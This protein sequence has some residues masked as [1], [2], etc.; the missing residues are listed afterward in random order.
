MVDLKDSTEPFDEG[1]ISPQASAP[2]KFEIAGR[3]REIGALI[4]LKGEN[5]FRAKAYEN[6]ASALESIGDEL[7][8][9]IA[10]DQLTA[11]KGIG[12]SI[13]GVINE[14]YKTGNAKSLDKLKAEFPPGILELGAIPG[15]SVKKVE[16]LHAALGISSINDLKNAIASNLI[17][18][19]KGFSEKSQLNIAEALAA[20]EARGE[21]M[22]LV[23]AK[24]VSENLLAYLEAEKCVAKACVVG[25]ISRWQEAVDKIELVASGENLVKILDAF[26]KFPNLS[27]VISRTNSSS[28]A[29]LSDSRLFINLTVCTTQD[30]VCTAHHLTGTDD[31]NAGLK[32]VAET[33]NLDLRPNELLEKGAKISLGSEH[34]IYDRLGLPFIPVELREDMQVITDAVAGTTYD[35]LIEIDDIRGMTHCHS[36]FSD[37]KA[38]V[39]EMA[40]AVKNM[41]K[42]YMTMTDHSPTAHYAN[43]VQPERLTEQWFAIA[44]AQGSVGIEILRGTESDI[45]ADGSLDYSDEILGQLDIVIASIHSRMKMDEDQMTDRLINCMRQ[46]RFKIWGHALGRLLL[47]RD[48]VKCRML[49]VLDAAANS[50]VAIEV[51][52]D[53]RRL[54]MEPKWLK[55]ARKRKMRFVISTDAH[56]T[57]NLQNLKFGVHLARRAAITKNEV[58]NT[59]SVE[60]FR[61]AVKP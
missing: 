12:A 22:L 46:K 20:Y 16:T 55:E 31:Y 1:G 28:S 21:Q 24:V 32:I 9:V 17:S 56:S 39:E 59:L 7:S 4:K 51:N 38:S 58:L 50:R 33:K 43:G 44:Q 60:D 41:N 6:A 23:H 42:E 8:D 48:P 29:R 37:G 54:D 25:A 14:L 47:K 18:A 57:A 27:E 40:M 45:L 35:D 3:L 19:V 61:R 2:D 53:P 15:L 36:T 13:A 30:F 26:E 11:V 10:R 5:V 34:D 52:G 49:D